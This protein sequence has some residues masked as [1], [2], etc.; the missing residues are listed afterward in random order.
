MNNLTVDDFYDILKIYYKSKELTYTIKDAM[1]E[2]K[3]VL[4][5]IKPN[6]YNKIEE[7]E[8][9]DF[10]LLVDSLEDLSDL[11]S[12]EFSQL[13]A[14]DEDKEHNAEKQYNLK[15]KIYEVCK[16]TFEDII[17]GG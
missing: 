16:S 7:L 8:E 15:N 10:K 5:D 13:Y 6:I 3:T 2:L 11:L 12:C 1:K 4:Q 14:M 9:N 17:F